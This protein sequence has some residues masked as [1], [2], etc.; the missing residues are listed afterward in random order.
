MAGPS[1]RFRLRIATAQL[2]YIPGRVTAQDSL[3][4][5]EEAGLGPDPLNDRLPP[6]A[7]SVTD[8]ADLTD[9]EIRLNRDTVRNLALENHRRKV[10]EILNYCVSNEINL[11]AL[12][13]YSMPAQLIPLVSTYQQDIP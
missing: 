10:Q 13:E 6:A 5:R 4:V 3:W 11:V 9:S 1:S 12:P 8:L 2:G 7:A